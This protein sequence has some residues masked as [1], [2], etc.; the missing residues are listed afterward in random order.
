MANNESSERRNDEIEVRVN[1]PVPDGGYGWVV[2]IGAFVN[3]EKL[4]I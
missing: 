3:K 2:L 1:R 4:Y